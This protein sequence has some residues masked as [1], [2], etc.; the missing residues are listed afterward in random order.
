MGE[1]RANY[2]TVEFQ[3]HLGRNEE[4]LGVPW[5]EFVGDET[6][7]HTFAVS[8]DDPTDD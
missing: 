5:A 2:A 3:E 1:R 7:R 4:S 6:D 8:T